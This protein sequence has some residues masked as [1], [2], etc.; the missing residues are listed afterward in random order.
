MSLH[1][2]VVHAGLL[3]EVLAEIQTEH[4]ANEA[5]AMRPQSTPPVLA[6]AFQQH[7]QHMQQQQQQHGFFTCR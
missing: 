6:H 7:G 5:A 1:P 3:E 2:P 4:R